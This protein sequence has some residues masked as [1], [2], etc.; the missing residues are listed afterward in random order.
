MKLAKNMKKDFKAKTFLYH[1][2]FHQILILFKVFKNFLR[3][4][5]KL[6]SASYQIFISPQ[7][8]AL[9]KLL[10]MFF[11][12]SPFFSPCQPLLQRLIKKNLIIHDVI[13]CQSTQLVRGSY[14]PF[15]RSTPP[16]SKIPPPFLE[17]QDVPTFHRTIR[18]TKELNNACNQFV[19]SFYP[20]S[21]LVLEECLHRW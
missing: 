17:I 7:M 19:Y 18:K 8:I 20:Q 3:S 4:S 1:V 9:Q 21:I 6:V 16:F 13:N 5:L 11:S 10:K 15:S 2:I 14:P 12:T